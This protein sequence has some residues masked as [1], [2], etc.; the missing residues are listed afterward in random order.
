MNCDKVKEL[1]WAYL[2][3]KT[4]A[5]ETA[6]IET[7]LEG[8]A[9]CRE[10]LAQQKEIKN[11]LASL[12]DEELPEDYHTELMQKLQAERKVVPFPAKKKHGWKQ[13]SMIA[14]A[15]L[16]V[17]V[18]GGTR[19]ML[20]MRQNQNEEIEQILFEDTALM[21]DTGE[22]A[23]EQTAADSA[24]E[25]NAAEKSDTKEDFS[26]Q[27]TKKAKKPV[28]QKTAP[29]E[30]TPKEAT[31]KEATPKETTPKETAKSFWSDGAATMP[32]AALYASE[33]EN[34]M[35]SETLVS[36]TRALDSNAA[37]S[38][39]LQVEK[40]ET[41]LQAIRKSIEE[42]GGYEGSSAG[43]VIQAVIPVANYADFLEQVGKLGEIQAF[44]QG[45]EDGA[46]R[47]ISISVTEK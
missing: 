9:A 13:M 27:E 22:E 16:V 24:T 44:F 41:A 40:K 6:E 32:K 36:G 25:N 20:E 30:T 11:A 29:K 4:T 35:D 26:E 37:D 34:A 14:A 39:T 47:T 5:E 45:E 43:D 19:G 38:M 12:P 10:E 18:A 46:S 15:V 42:A 2:E 28:L 21:A 1:L 3:N 7:H 33:A 8:C 23:A 31:P 17:V